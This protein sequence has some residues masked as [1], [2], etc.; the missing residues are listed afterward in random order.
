[1]FFF[2]KE[3]EKNKIFIIVILFL[4]AFATLR[5][6]NIIHF[7]NYEFQINA[8]MN[9][10]KGVP[11]WKAYQNRLLAP[12]IIKLISD[13]SPLDIKYSY[14]AFMLLFLTLYSFISYFVFY[15]ICKCDKKAILYTLFSFG[16]FIFLQDER[17]LYSWD[18][19]DLNIFTLFI[20]AIVKQK[21]IGFF[22]IIFFIELLNREIALF[23]PLWLIID[24]INYDNILRKITF[25]IKKLVISISLLLTGIIYIKFVR[26]YMFIESSIPGIGTDLAHSKLGNHF[27]LF[28]NLK[29]FFI[30]NPISTNL[31]IVING[32][33][34][35]IIL[36]II[37]LI[38]N[39]RDIYYKKI[40]LL[41][42]TLFSST[43]LFGVLNESRLYFIFIPL[44][45]V[46]YLHVQSSTLRTFL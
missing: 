9:V 42:F 36:F 13:F 30:E 45:L 16:I 7:N 17:F 38:K 40:A 31:D 11:H 46:V 39:V 32:I 21:K 28:E 14:K 34:V 3:N 33:I 8:S 35:T 23:I 26:E 22:T 6:V 12:Y 24:S 20:Y 27:Y 19:I 41:I 5:V 43:L 29:L 25:N 1:M 18:F 10:L 15:K 4:I 44:I 2:R 37:Y